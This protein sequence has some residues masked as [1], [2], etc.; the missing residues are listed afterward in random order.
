MAEIAQTRQPQ[1]VA[2]I[3][4]CPSLPPPVAS[5]ASVAAPRRR[6]SPPAI[7]VTPRPGP[8][9]FLHGRPT[10]AHPWKRFAGTSSATIPKL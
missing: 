2:M 5:A 10:A 3:A 4:P 1:R 8:K 9:T 7:P 6:V